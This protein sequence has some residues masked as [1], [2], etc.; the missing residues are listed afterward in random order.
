MMHAPTRHELP[1]HAALAADPVLQQV[2]ARLTARDRPGAFAVAAEAATRH[3]THAFYAV[4]AG[5][6]ARDAGLEAEAMRWFTHALALEPTQTEALAWVAAAWRRRGDPERA[7]ALARR[8]LAV[9]PDHGE[10]LLTLAQATYDLGDPLGALS[11][12]DTA[13]RLHG[14]SPA[15]GW[16]RAFA[17]LALEQFAEGWRDHEHRLAVGAGSASAPGTEGTAWHGE[18]LEG[19]SI[20]VRA[21]QGLGDQLM[22]SRF[23]P[24]LRARGAGSIIVEC[25]APIAPLIATMPEVDMVVRRGDPLPATDRTVPVSS[26][27]ARLGVGSALWGHTVPYVQAPGTCP[28]ALEATLAAPAPL[29]VGIVWG[30]EPRNFSDHERSIPLVEWAPL[31]QLPGIAWYS[32]Q[33]GPREA[34]LATLAPAL[35]DRVTDLAPHLRDFGDTAHAIRRLDLVVTVCTSVAHAAGALGAPTW[36]LLRHAADWRWFR[37]RADSPWYPSARLFRQRKRGAW[38]PVLLEVAHAL[39]E[40]LRGPRR[41]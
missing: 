22:M 39:V 18:P 37:E 29:K 30:G 2:R 1:D 3:P 6:T 7:A 21:E 4:L 32:L 25:G 11:V 13:L 27:P 38:G 31:L 36:I 34:E 10:S 16:T 33:K 12:A 41:V 40:R 28:A 19:R 14:D 20:A 9:R 15:L 8:A 23:I 17:H 24:G 5:A 26:L 35:Q